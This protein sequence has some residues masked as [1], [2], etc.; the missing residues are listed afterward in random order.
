MKTQSSNPEQLCFSIGRPLAI[1]LEEVQNSSCNQQLTK[2][3][4]Q[5]LEGLRTFEQANEIGISTSNK[6][7]TAIYEILTK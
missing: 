6:T 4:E 2:A 7:S 3:A 5:M 1:L